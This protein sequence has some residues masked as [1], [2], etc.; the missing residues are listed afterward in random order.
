[1]LP[2]VRTAG[3]YEAKTAGRGYQGSKKKKKKRKKFQARYK[4][5]VKLV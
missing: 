2:Q 5:G 3:T 4:L 1:M